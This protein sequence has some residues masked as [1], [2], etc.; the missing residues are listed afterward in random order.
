MFDHLAEYSP[1]ILIFL[2]GALI[3][4][5]AHVNSGSKFYVFDYFTDETSG[6]ASITRTLQM[7]GGLT[8]TWI[9]VKMAVL[10]TITA[11][12]FGIYLAALGVS[13]AWSKYIGAKYGSIAQTPDQSTTE[14]QPK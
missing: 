2:I 9:V 7:L 10:G 6:K 14:E 4:W 8:A 13:A 12:I 11:E 5:R 3:I 1:Q